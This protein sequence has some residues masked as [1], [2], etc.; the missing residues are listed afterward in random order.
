[1]NVS[2]DSN[3]STSIK[4]TWLC[5]DCDQYNSTIGFLISYKLDSSNQTTAVAVN[6]SVGHFVISGLK[7]FTNYTIYVSSVTLRGLSMSSEKV[8]IRTLEDG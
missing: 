2:A 3:T 6:R 4:V 1:M 7:K 5:A 8:S